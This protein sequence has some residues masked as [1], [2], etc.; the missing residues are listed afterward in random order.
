MKA[1]SVS[2]AALLGTVAAS[3]HYFFNDGNTLQTLRDRLAEM[4][5]RAL[6]IQAAA[7]AAKRDF[8]EEETKDLDQ[9]FVD[10]AR[11]EGDISRREQIEANTRSIATGSGRRTEPSDPIDGDPAG[12]PPAPQA[13]GRQPGRAPVPTRDK[14][15]AT[16]RGADYGRRGW[17]NVGYFARGVM[18]ASRPG[19]AVDPRL[20]V[21]APTTF[22]SE[23][24]GADGGF[25]V[26]PEFRTAIMEKVMGESSLLARCDLIDTAGN[27]ITIPT[28]ETTPWQTTGG[29][30]AYWE[31]EG[32]QITQSKPSL[33]DTTIRLNKLA[34]LVPVTTELLEDAAALASYIGRKAPEKIDFKVNLAIIQGTGVGQPMGI[35]HSQALIAVAEES[36]QTTFTVNLANVSKMWSRLYGPARQNAVWLINQDVEQQLNVLGFPSTGA[37]TLQFPIYM[38]PGGLAGAPYATL[39]GKPVLVTQACNALGYQGDIILTDLKAYLVAQKVGGLRAETSI[40][41]WFD[42]DQVAFRFILRLAGQPWWSTVISARDTNAHSLSHYVTLAARTS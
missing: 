14:A 9:I 3:P 41:L 24:V 25:A 23:G 37:T 40:H 33:Q 31:G 7:D 12:D 16:A 32:Q 27:S 18:M 38:P 42:Y 29:V 34:A 1:F 30:L 28:D 15:P 8:T 10:I 4:N 11:T 19:G 26:P 20:L 6:T 21:D 39:Y 13:A 35:L 2:M 36:S 5:D 22:G 17:Q